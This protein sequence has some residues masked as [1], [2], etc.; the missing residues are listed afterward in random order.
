[1]LM[2]CL[3]Y[4]VFPQMEVCHTQQDRWFLLNDSISTMF[5]KGVFDAFQSAVEKFGL[6][7]RVHSDK[8]KENTDIAWFMLSHPL[9]GPDC[10][11]HIAGQS[12]HN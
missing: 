7:S 1:M 5:N 12:V 10:G 4:L 3:T 8:G 9:Q 2:I 11:S 6:P